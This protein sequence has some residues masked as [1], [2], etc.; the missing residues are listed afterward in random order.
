MKKE[1]KLLI[2][3]LFNDEELF[4]NDLLL[5]TID[6]M[7]NKLPYNTKLSPVIYKLLNINKPRGFLY[8]KNTNNE[9][10]QYVYETH[11]IMYMPK[12][13][14][15][16]LNILELNKWIK[17]NQTDLIKT[18]DNLL[19]NLG[20]KYETQYNKLQYI[21]FSPD[22]T[23]VFI[24]FFNNQFH[25]LNFILTFSGETT[26]NNF[27]SKDENKKI[28]QQAQQI[29]LKMKKFK[30][31]LDDYNGLKYFKHFAVQFDENNDPYYIFTTNDLQN[32]NITIKAFEKARTMYKSTTP[33]ML[34]AITELESVNNPY[35]HVCF[36][37]DKEHKYSQNNYACII[38]LT[39]KGKEKFYNLL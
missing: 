14:K 37:N 28:K 27:I 3:N 31:F 17:I 10:E 22:R 13:V 11:K 1:I 33:T 16:I 2:E 21:Y 5:D 19:I 4:N 34:N 15:E 30:K 29:K 32:I 8:K 20:N 24:C 38:K 26:E 9:Y 18:E 7:Y 36:I 23:L 35:C 39:D 12:Y 6:D 25:T